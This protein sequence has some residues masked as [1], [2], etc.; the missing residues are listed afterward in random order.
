MKSDLD[1][2]KVTGDDDVDG[3]GDPWREHGVGKETELDWQESVDVDAEESM[4]DGRESD[5]SEETWLTCR[6]L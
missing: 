4:L 5:E 6:F 1:V 3:S 2:A